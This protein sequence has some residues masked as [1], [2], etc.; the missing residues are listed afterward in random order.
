MKISVQLNIIFFILL[1]GFCFLFIIN[2]SSRDRLVSQVESLEEE[3]AILEDLN[4]CEKLLLK[5]MILGQ[6]VLLVSGGEVPGDLLIPLRLNNSQIV[7]H[8]DNIRKLKGDIAPVE[9]ITGFYNFLNEVLIKKLFNKEPIESAVI[10]KDLTLKYQ[11]LQKALEEYREEVR[12]THEN[13]LKETQDS[14]REATGLQIGVSFCLLFILLF[15]ML[16][17][18]KTLLKPIRVMA[19]KMSELV[20][21]GA[22]LAFRFNDPGNDEISLV[23]SRFDDFMQN[24]QEMMGELSRV[25]GSIKE[26]GKELD[27]G[28]GTNR[29]LTTTFVKSSGELTENFKKFQEVFRRS[30]NLAS[31]SMAHVLRVD[32]ISDSNISVFNQTLIKMEELISGVSSSRQ[33]SAEALDSIHDLHGIAETGL[34]TITSLNGRI[35][36]ISKIAENIQ[37]INKFVNDLADRTHILGINAA[38]EAAG[39]SRSGS[40]FKVVADEIN[41]LSLQVREGTSEI[42]SNLQETIKV[43]D[44][45]KNESKSGEELFNRIYLKTKEIREEMN[46]AV[47]ELDSQVGKSENFVEK[48]E[49]LKQSNSETRHCLTELTTDIIAMTSAINDLEGEYQSSLICLTDFQSGIRELEDLSDNLTAVGNNNFSIVRALASRIAHFEEEDLNLETRG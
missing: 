19:D 11:D 35:E 33:R 32:S 46:I 26:A 4:D 17:Q 10:V 49:D 25:S 44:A 39:G 22:S 38:I 14:M 29:E 31:T 16:R 47:G 30:D 15:F 6:D 40:G 8:V 18:R 12:L 3:A 41:G 23:S 34:R 42:Y 43:V 21:G 37:S 36:E 45:L 48:V 7:Q 28:I 13:S 20:A 5:Q 27:K 2:L 1:S 24:L 9:N